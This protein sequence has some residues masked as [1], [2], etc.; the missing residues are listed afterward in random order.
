MYGTLIKTLPEEIGDLTSLNLLVLTNSKIEFLPPSIGNLRSLKALWMY[1][2]LIKTLPEEIGNLSSLEVL[3]AEVTPIASL[4]AC[5]GRLSCLKQ[6]YLHGTFIPEVREANNLNDFLWK[7]VREFPMLG[8]LGPE[9]EKRRKNLK[10]ALAC[11]RARYRIQNFEI[12]DGKKKSISI[13]PKL[14]PF[15]FRHSRNAFK[16]YPME[17]WKY[18]EF[19][20]QTIEQSDAIYQLLDIGREL[21]IKLLVDMRM[22]P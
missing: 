1:G 14:L 20:F 17:E 21:F 18:D 22:D 7:L 9:L 6:L 3:N 10:F 5:F 8:H 16:N 12:N 13:V 15:I 11:N 19:M 4:P 2:T